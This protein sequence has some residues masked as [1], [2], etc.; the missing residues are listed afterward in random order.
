MMWA[1]DSICPTSPDNGGPK[2]SEL[3]SINPA[4]EDCTKRMGW[5]SENVSEEFNLNRDELDE[6]AAASFQKAERAEKLGLFAEEIVP[7]TVF[8]NDPKTGERRTVTITKD[9][10][11][12][13]G[14]TKEGLLKIRPAFP[15]WGKSTTTG[16]NASQITDGA[17]A[18]LLMTRRK[19]EELALPILGKYVTTAVTGQ[20]RISAFNPKFQPLVG[21]PP[22][23]MGIGPVFAIPLALKLS[24]ITQE[25]V[26]LFEV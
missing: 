3:I 11:I 5:T 9:D 12:R 6:F 25:D 2:Q 13:Y 18:V 22:R 1:I 4:S 19:A 21:V 20:Y 23:I 14:T 7:F 26:D 16:G 17:A 10:G 8:Q 15:Q 24:G